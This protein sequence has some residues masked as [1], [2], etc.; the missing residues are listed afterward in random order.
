LPRYG[1]DVSH[2][3]EKLVEGYLSESD[4]WKFWTPNSDRV[5]QYIWEVGSDILV[6]REEIHTLRTWLNTRWHRFL[7]EKIK[8]IREGV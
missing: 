1:Y 6:S 4:I 8:G 7:A 2:A 3:L 5:M